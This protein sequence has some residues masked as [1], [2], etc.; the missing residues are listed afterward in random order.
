MRY[1]EEKLE[2]GSLLRSEVPA[3][4]MRRALFHLMVGVAGR[5]PLPT[6]YW[7]FNHPESKAGAFVR[8]AGVATLGPADLAPDQERRAARLQD[9]YAKVV[10]TGDCTTSLTPGEV[11]AP[12]REGIVTFAAQVRAKVGAPAAAE[13]RGAR[14]SAAPLSGRGHLRRT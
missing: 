7:H 2:S 10:R 5:V 6:E 14:R 1:F 9:W 3:L 8:G 4:R 12:T 13:R 11:I